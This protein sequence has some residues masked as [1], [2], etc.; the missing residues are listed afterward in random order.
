MNLDI[1]FNQCVN[2]AQHLSNSKS[3]ARS[4]CDY[5]TN[6]MNSCKVECSK[7]ENKN[8]TEILQKCV[9][10][11]SNDQQLEDCIKNSNLHSTIRLCKVKCE[12]KA[13]QDYKSIE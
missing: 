3:A 10:I 2:K 5:Y 9:N 8:Q 1:E 6:K 13:L 7:T 12:I 11:S 4:I